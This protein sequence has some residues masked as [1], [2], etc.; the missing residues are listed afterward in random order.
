MIAVAASA[1]MPKPTRATSHP[2][3]HKM[4]PVKA[5]AMPSSAINGRAVAVPPSAVAN[6]KAT[7]ATI[8][9]F[10]SKSAKSSFRLA[11]VID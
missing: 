6:A 3:T 1:K 7:T 10:Q 11:V 2:V 5:D 4:P 9:R 8:Y